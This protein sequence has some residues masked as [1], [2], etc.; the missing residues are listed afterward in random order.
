MKGIYT[1]TT[2]SAPNRVFYIEWRTEYYSGIGGTA[3]YEVVLNENDRVLK[4][5]YGQIDTAGTS[6]TEGVQDTGTGTSRRVRLQR[7]RWG[8][9][10]RHGRGL[11]AKW[12]A[13]ASATAASS[14]AVEQRGSVSVNHR[15][16]RV[17]AGR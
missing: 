14:G 9:Q 5:I 7:C 3:N 12:W 10:P 2:G 4:T 15:P 13:A 1:T 11:H 8:D 16:L 17:R 6:S